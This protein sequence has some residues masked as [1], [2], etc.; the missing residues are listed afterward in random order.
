MSW[1]KQYR[2]KSFSQLHLHAARESLS[3]LLL[4]PILP[5]AYL[6]SGPKGTGK[7]SASRILS[8]VL[9]DPRNATFVADRLASHS[10][11]AG[12]AKKLF[13]PDDS[14]E[15]VARILNGQSLAVHELD[16]ASNLGI[17]DIR[18]LK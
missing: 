14:E 17:D 6:F 9:N 4:Q 8:A 11:K 10:R 5:Q 7:T 1:N 3:Q 13:E 12:T 18:A 16:A 2:P 15:L